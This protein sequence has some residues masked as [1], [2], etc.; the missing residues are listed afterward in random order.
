MIISV[1]LT[2][3][4]YALPCF[5][6]DG[7]LDKMEII[8]SDSSGKTCSIYIY[9]QQGDGYTAGFDFNRDAQSLSGCFYTVSADGTNLFV[10]RRPYSDYYTDIPIRISIT[11]TGEQKLAY[12]EIMN[13]EVSASVATAIELRDT[14]DDG[15]CHDFITKGDYIFSADTQKVISSCYLRIWGANRLKENITNAAWDNTDVW[16][17]KPPHS[18]A[19]AYIFI[20]ASAQVKLPLS[21]K[22]VVDTINN[23]GTLIIDE[24]SELTVEK[25]LNKGKIHNLGILNSTEIILY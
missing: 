22:I 5:R 25:V 24:T 15:L 4:V 3:G 13:T 2:K 9:M 19:N 8:Y 18:G 20:P 17:G 21:E 23:E 14:A 1:L 6:Q 11:N 16:E 12:R 7:I 10:D